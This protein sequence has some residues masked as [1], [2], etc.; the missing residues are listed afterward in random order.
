M[1]PLVL[2]LAL[3]A[4]GG[5]RGER[6]LAAMRVRV[7]R[8]APAAVSVLSGVIGVALVGFGVLSG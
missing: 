5:E 3:R 8:W 6:W 4:L 2:I 7:T 1:L